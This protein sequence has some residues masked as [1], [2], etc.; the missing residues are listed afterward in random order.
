MGSEGC[1]DG[2]DGLGVRDPFGRGQNRGAAEAVTDQDRGR[3]AGLAQ[4]IGGTDEI[5]DVG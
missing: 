1:C 2:D 4:M 3:L 5:G